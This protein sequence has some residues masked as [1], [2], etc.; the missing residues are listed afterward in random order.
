MAGFIDDFLEIENGDWIDL[1]KL[2]HLYKIVITESE[3]GL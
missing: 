2:H 3:Q 1:R